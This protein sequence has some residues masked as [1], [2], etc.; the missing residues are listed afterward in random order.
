MQRI[1]S[2]LMILLIV[3]LSFNFSA[4]GEAYYYW[5]GLITSY[6][7]CVYYGDCSGISNSSKNTVSFIAI[8]DNDGKTLKGAWKAD[9]DGVYY[10]QTFEEQGKLTIAQHD[11]SD[12]S[13]IRFDSGTYSTEGNKLIIDMENGTFSIV[14][15]A[16]SN[17]TLVLSEFV[18]EEET[19]N[20]IE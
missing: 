8:D 1:I 20:T 17:K 19:I 12:D 10:I 5:F 9:A 15:F 6:I 4:C 13:I 16:I 11:N 2:V 18:E 14:K 7:A 3:S